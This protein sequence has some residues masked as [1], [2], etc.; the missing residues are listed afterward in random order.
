MRVPAISQSPCLLVLDLHSLPLAHCLTCVIVIDNR[1]S[2]LH[3]LR[4]SSP[5]SSTMD[6]PSRV[7]SKGKM[8][9]NQRLW[10]SAWEVATS[11]SPTPI[12]P[13]RSSSSPQHSS[14]PIDLNLISRIPTPST[15]ASQ[16]SPH[17][18]SLNPTLSRHPSLRETSPSI[19]ITFHQHPTQHPILRPQRPSNAT[20][21]LPAFLQSMTDL[22]LQAS[23][24]AS[25]QPTCLATRPRPQR[26]RNDQPNL[27][28]PRPRR[29]LRGR[30][31]S[32]MC[33]SGR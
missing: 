14:K 26:P 9:S 32:K 29:R 11:N 31:R 3:D 16:T 17:S 25:L 30:V 13:Q 18:H 5:P 7:L 6:S 24:N 15:P 8:W 23:A 21:I 19:P 1:T 22:H 27:P 2:C 12:T 10:V 28:Y 33:R 4:R 20:T